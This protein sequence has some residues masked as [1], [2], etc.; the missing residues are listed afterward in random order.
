[1]LGYFISSVLLAELGIIAGGTFLVLSWDIMEPISYL[2]GLTNFVGGFGW[3]YM[4]V[5]KPDF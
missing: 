1:M 3:Y 2:M 4:F 5:T